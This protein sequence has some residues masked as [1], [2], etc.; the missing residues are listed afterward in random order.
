M[1]LPLTPPSAQSGGPRTKGLSRLGRR[2]LRAGADRRRADR[3][4]LLVGLAAAPLLFLAYAGLGGA[5]TS[6]PGPAW[7]VVV[8]AVAFAGAAVLA[9]YVPRAGQRVR[10]AVGCAPCA[11]MPVL[12]TVG[13]GLLIASAPGSTPMALAALSIVAFGLVQ[14]RGAP[15]A[16]CSTS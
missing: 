10:D 7:L 9:D 14:R 2:T 12:T 4:R 11:A 3:R 6:A 1:H 13:A 8:G 15:V 16:A 5:L